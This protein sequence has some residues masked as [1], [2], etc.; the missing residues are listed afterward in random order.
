MYWCLEIKGALL[1]YGDVILWLVEWPI[2]VLPLQPDWKIWVTVEAS[3]IRLSDWSLSWTIRHVLDCFQLYLNG[4]VTSSNASWPTKTC[5]HGWTY[6][7]S[8]YFETAATDVS[9]YPGGPSHKL[10]DLRNK[11]NIRTFRAPKWLVGRSCGWKF[12]LGWAGVVVK[13]SARLVR[14]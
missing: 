13:W 6:D 1:S 3:K 8:D 11:T 2:G 4:S 14:D 7:F 12:R 5:S 9:S 10:I